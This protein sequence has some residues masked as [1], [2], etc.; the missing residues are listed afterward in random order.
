MPTIDVPLTTAVPDGLVVRPEPDDGTGL[1]RFTIYHAPTSLR[2]CGPA[3]DRCATH[4]NQVL[5]VITAAGIDWTQA[6]S[7]PDNRAR[8]MAM[9]DR[10]RDE[11][12]LCF[13]PETA[14]SRRCA[15]DRPA[16]FTRAPQ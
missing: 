5:D 13:D 16:R 15:G 14:K 8:C 12:G 3:G 6:N 10:L 1:A 11:V 7:V 9:N 4:L 2:L